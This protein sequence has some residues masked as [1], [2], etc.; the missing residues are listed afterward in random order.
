[1]R[2]LQIESPCIN[3]CTMHEA[4]GLCLGCARTI[5]EIARWSGSSDASRAQVLAR[6]PARRAVLQA[7]GVLIDSDPESR[8]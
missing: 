1:M 6:L 8:P 3:V 5:D 7:Q 4:T 2:A